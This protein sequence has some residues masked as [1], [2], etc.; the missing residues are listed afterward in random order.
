MWETTDGPVYLLY[1]RTG[2]CIRCYSVVIIPLIYS[3][4]RKIRV[5]L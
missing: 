3:Y 5:W 4:M 1:C 2:L